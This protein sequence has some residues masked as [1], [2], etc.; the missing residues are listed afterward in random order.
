[1]NDVWE[2]VV[3]MAAENTDKK[4]YEA[5][6]D[7]GYRDYLFV[8]AGGSLGVACGGKVIVMPI[9]EWHRLG[10]TDASSGEQ[11]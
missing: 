2:D 3:C 8:T 7:E 9:R 5:P 6:G 4:I 11:P 10:S 1:M